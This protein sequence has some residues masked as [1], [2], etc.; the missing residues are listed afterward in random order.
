MRLPLLALAVLLASAAAGTVT[1]DDDHFLFRSL[2]V[3]DL[4]DPVYIPLGADHTGK[5]RRRTTAVQRTVDYDP[6]LLVGALSSLNITDILYEGV[7]KM[8]KWSGRRATY[9]ATDFVPGFCRSAAT[10]RI[11]YK[12][13]DS[14]TSGYFPGLK[15]TLSALSA[16]TQNMSTRVRP[17]RSRQTYLAK[18]PVAHAALLET[19]SV[20]VTPQP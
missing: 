20:G 18:P 3:L 5:P 16:S 7:S 15:A 4:M 11:L 13:L 17:S 8:Q 14:R 6:P 10:L 9:D 19:A 12:I 2:A 1:S